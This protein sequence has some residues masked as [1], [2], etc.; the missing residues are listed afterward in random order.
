MR[1]VYWLSALFVAGLAAWLPSAHA[2]GLLKPAKP[3][4]EP[5]FTMVAE[6]C[7]KDVVKKV[8][9]LV[10]DVKKVSKWVYDCKSEDFCLKRCP[11][12]KDKCCNDC[13]ECAKCDRPRTKTVLL[14]K[15][16]VEECPTTKCIVEEVCE[17]VAY[18]VYRKVPCGTTACPT[19]PH[20][21]AEQIPAPKIKMPEADPEI[22]FP[23]APV[24]VIPTPVLLPRDQK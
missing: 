22:S 23:H 6:V 17:K 8:C 9:R 15:L 2:S 16:V 18:T 19:V 7:Y 10:P 13:A 5:G 11:L 14:K 20:P 3:A 12:H 1:H 24:L 21:G 4:C